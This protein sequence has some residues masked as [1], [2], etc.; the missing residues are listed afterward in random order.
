MALQYDHV[1]NYCFN[2]FPIEARDEFVIQVNPDKQSVSYIPINTKIALHKKKKMA[3]F[4]Q[5][6]DLKKRSEQNPKFIQVAPRSFTAKEINKITK[7]NIEFETRMLA[8]EKGNHF[9]N[10]QDLLKCEKGQAS[11]KLNQMFAD[12]MKKNEELFNAKQAQELNGFHQTRREN[13]NGDDRVDIMMQ[14]ENS[15]N[16]FGNDGQSNKSDEEEVQL[17]PKRNKKLKRAT[18]DSDKESEKRQDS[19][20]DHGKKQLSED[21][22]DLF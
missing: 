8:I 10:R 7:Q 17:N 15:D 18:I 9:D 16:L 1:R 5:D 22:N 14:S 11:Q 2:Q 21:E 3:Q 20:E 12:R 4:T 13:E 19:E 6:D